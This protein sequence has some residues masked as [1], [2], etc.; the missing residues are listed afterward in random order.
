MSDSEKR[1]YTEINVRYHNDDLGDISPETYENL[2]SDQQKKYKRTIDG[3]IRTNGKSYMSTAVGPQART[4][5]KNATAL[6]SANVGRFGEKNG[7]ADG[8][9]AIGS[10]SNAA[11][12]NATALGFHSIAY[13]KDAVTIGANTRTEVAGAV[14]LGSESQATVGAGV[15][16]YDPMVPGRK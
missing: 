7:M 1:N 16:G 9:T 6:G 10:S 5:G 11:Y 8:G 15:Y 14:A 4:Y 12:E 3:Y 2:P 13:A